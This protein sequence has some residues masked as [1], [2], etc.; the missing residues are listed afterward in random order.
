MLYGQ[1]SIIK[2]DTKNTVDDIS[3]Q[4]YIVHLLTVMKTIQE[5]L[6]LPNPVAE[7]G[8]ELVLAVMLAS[9]ALSAE[10]RRLLRDTDLT[11]A[12]LNVLMLLMYQFPDGTTQTALSKRMFVNRA[13]VTGLIDRLERDD[14]V[15]R[16]RLDRDRRSNT[17]TITPKGRETLEAALPDYFEGIQA[18]SDSI[19]RAELDNAVKVLLN[20]CDLMGTR[21]GSRS[22]E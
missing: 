1:Q 7:E 19:P 8:H 15:Q 9:K 13:N 2:K 6:D 16:I 21:A 18:I 20:L 3:V 17:V 11:E 4:M 12:Q 5:Q 22:T 10:A 14:L